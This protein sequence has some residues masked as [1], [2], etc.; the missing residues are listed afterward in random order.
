MYRDKRFLIK[1][2]EEINA[3]IADARVTFPGVGRVFLCDG[4]A[5]SVP[6]PQ[7]IG[8]LRAI[9]DGLPDVISVSCYASAKSIASKTDGEL[10]E[11]RSLN[12][13]LLH[14]GLES[15]DDVTLK[16]MQKHGN[17]EFHVLQARRAK[18]VKMRLFVTVLLGL[19]GRARAR[20]HALATARAL[21]EMSPHYVGALS[22]LLIPG[23]PLYEDL[24][25]GQFCVPNPHELL[26]ELRTILERTEM[27]GV[28]FANHASNH[29]PLRARL[30][31]D[32]EEAIAQV[33]AALRGE[34]PLKPEW[35]RGT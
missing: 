15:G 1:C 32:R 22:L 3:D 12:L 16:R 5:L 17:A 33:D 30:P 11:L 34:L 20:E 10:A 19:G 13:K 31:R 14:M 18:D 24:I 28:F 25:R 27:R 2:P 35:L 21:S 8:I 9:R 6:Q 23:T 26:L 7:L 29:L 4:D